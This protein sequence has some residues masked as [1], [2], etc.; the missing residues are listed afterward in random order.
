MKT[1]QKTI[2]LF[3]GMLLSSASLY[4][5]NLELEIQK[6]TVDTK[7]GKGSVEYDANKTN[8]E[9]IIEACNKSGF[10]CS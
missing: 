5:A 10:S 7:T 3:L 4:A 2:G 8:P 9:K 6:C 1:Y